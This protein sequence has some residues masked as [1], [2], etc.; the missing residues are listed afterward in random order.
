MTIGFI[1]NTVTG[2]GLSTDS[3]T[4]LRGSEIMQNNAQLTA[5][6]FPNSTT[7]YGWNMDSTTDTAATGA[8]AG[9]MFGTSKDLTITADKM[10]T[11]NDVLGN[12]KYCSFDGAAYLVSTDAAFNFTGTFS[13]AGW[14]YFASWTNSTEECLISRWSSAGSNNGWIIRKDSDNVIAMTTSHAGTSEVVF[15]FST[16]GLAAGWHHIA[17]VRTA[18]AGS[19]LYIDGK[20]MVIGIANTIAEGGQLEVGSRNAGTAKMTGYADE[21][22]IHNA[23]AWTANEVLKIYARSAKKFAITDANS[24]VIVS[25]NSP[26]YYSGTFTPTVT[27]VGGAG[28]TTPVYSTN[29]GRYTRIGNRC[30]V[31]VILSGDGGAEGAGTGVVNIAL[32]MAVSASYATSRTFIGRGTNGTTI[33]WLCSVL[34]ASYTTISLGYLTAL[35]VG[36]TSLTGADQN[37]TTRQIIINF[38]YEV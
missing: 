13:V 17:V 30:F 34:E 33:F 35:N 21:I 29:T 22:V 10:H 36:L 11:A 19:C 18:A 6:D 23:T 15:S 26:V 27:L 5:T 25:E 32:P 4:T 28:N 16:V 8:Y 1:N 37:N 2:G 24:S 38:S 12:S 14:F 9:T 20:L 3:T 7:L 31:D